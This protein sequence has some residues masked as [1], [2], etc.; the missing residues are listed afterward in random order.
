M[1]TVNAGLMVGIE[2]FSLVHDSFGVPFGQLEAFHRAIRQQFVDIYSQNVL[3]NLR[4]QQI[5]QFPDQEAVYPDPED[6]KPGAYNI[7]EVNDALYF[8]R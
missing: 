5:A 6:V 2:D 8:F 3:A 7:E 4:L 1:K